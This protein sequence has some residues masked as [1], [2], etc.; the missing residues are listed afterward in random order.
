MQILYCVGFN[1]NNLSAIIEHFYDDITI[2][3]GKFLI[4]IIGIYVIST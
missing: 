1:E 2:E 3:N 4:G